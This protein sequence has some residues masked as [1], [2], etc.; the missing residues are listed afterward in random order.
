MELKI[1]EPIPEVNYIVMDSMTGELYKTTEAK[2]LRAEKE[3]NDLML[4][5]GPITLHEWYEIMTQD[6]PEDER[7][8]FFERLNSRCG[9]V[10]NEERL[11]DLI[12]NG[13]LMDDGKLVV[14]F[15]YQRL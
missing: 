4:K 11:E 2:L 10:V 6:W 14:R 9:W 8:K 1:N 15:D 5:K 3:F 12:L 13:I 7:V